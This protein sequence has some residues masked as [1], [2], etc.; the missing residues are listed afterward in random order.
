M[1]QR[2]LQTSVSLRAAVN[3]VPF[4]ATTFDSFLQLAHRFGLHGDVQRAQR[5]LQL[6][7][8]RAA[9][10]LLGADELADAVAVEASCVS[11]E[12]LGLAAE[13]EAAR[14]RL[15]QRQSESLHEL[16][17]ASRHGCL[18][19]F[20]A[21]ADMSER[22][23][24]SLA[25]RAACSQRLLQRQ[26]AAEQ[27]LRYA[28]CQG[29]LGAVRQCCSEALSLGLCSAIAAVQQHLDARRQEAAVQLAVSTRA[30]CE[31]A[32][33]HVEAAKC[34]GPSGSD[35]TQQLQSWRC[36][37]EQLAAS[38]AEAGVEAAL[39]QPPAVGA[40]WPEQVTCWLADARSAAGLELAAA[41][42]QAV[43]TF[44]D[45][46]RALEATACQGS[47]RLLPAKAEAGCKTCCHSTLA[48]HALACY[49][50]WQ[51]LQRPLLTRMAAAAQQAAGGGDSA[52]GE[53]AQASTAQFAGCGLAILEL[54]AMSSALPVSSGLARLRLL[55]LSG[56]RLT[57][58]ALAAASLSVAVPL[59][60]ELKLAGNQLTDL[61]W[62]GLLPN[63]LH[64][65]ASHNSLC[66]LEGLAEAAPLL[67][68][69]TGTSA[70]V[71]TMSPATASTCCSSS[72]CRS[73]TRH[74]MA[75]F[76]IQPSF[77]CRCLRLAG[78]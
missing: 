18:Q 5:V 7:R 47:I 69:W 59:L 17:Q 64:L 53:P 48:S 74:P 9:L 22:L 42:A 52:A 77:P 51:A 31:F 72:T 61:A 19:Q 33:Q 45:H 25:Q 8:R 40:S 6:R 30:A 60:T 46:L 54:A 13:A 43:D 21:A 36:W 78:S 23:G 24:V 28:A 27:R 70:R 3:A 57:S 29:N 41:V 37:S 2:N 67:Q 55:D 12:Q 68:V 34:A 39:R 16:L 65:D 26:Q 20:T 14:E 10:R 71:T 58:A 15:G 56:N 1:A 44:R 63:L 38:M 62:M 73:S 4:S 75:P 76:S 32:S 66:S 49:Q 11:A 35:C 50:Q